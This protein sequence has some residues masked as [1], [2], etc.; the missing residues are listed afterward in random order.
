MTF[1]LFGDI[2]SLDIVVTDIQPGAFLLDE[3]GFIISPSGAKLARV[4]SGA[5]I[6]LYDKRTKQEWFIKI[7]LLLQLLQLEDVA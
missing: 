5:G 6:W 2:M 1:V 3:R 4:S 7:E